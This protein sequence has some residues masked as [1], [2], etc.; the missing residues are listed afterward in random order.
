M[1]ITALPPREPTIHVS[2]VG[3]IGRYVAR[4][5]LDPAPLYGRY[6]WTPESID[7]GQVRVPLAQFF[8]LLESAAEYS[9]DRHFGLHVYES[10]DFA[11][12]GL[13]GFA[14]LSAE[15]VGAALRTLMR[16][17]AVFQ[18]CDDGQLLTDRDFAYLWYRVD[19]AVLAPCRHDCDMSTA[20]PVFFL[21]KVVDPFWAPIAVQLQHAM[22]SRDSVAEY[23]RVFRCPVSFGAATNQV[24]M[25]SRI[26]SAPIRSSDKRL[27]D[28][29]ERNLLLLQ[30]QVPREGS[31]AKRVEAAVIQKLSSGPPS[32]EAIAAVLGYSVRD[33][34]RLLA[35]RGLRFSTLVDIARKEL[36]TRL[37]ATT[38][39]SLAE[40]TYLLGYSEET[41][42]IRAFRRWMDCTPNDYRRSARRGTN[43]GM[44]AG[45]AR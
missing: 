9:G 36:A 15:D 24:T 39:R 41:A 21:R 2:Y 40:I 30:E 37:L 3:A 4:L 45:L 25:P 27:F 32:L 18:D 29:I 23:E 14:L 43:T 11:D 38:A 42:F 28:V 44:D 20:F 12:L 35:E 7:D 34:Q 5:G 26:L 6:G 19:S 16:Y 8:A 22:P 33:F 17:G 13:L 10:L 31:L 1:S